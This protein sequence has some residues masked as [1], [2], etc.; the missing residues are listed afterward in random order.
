MNLQDTKKKLY[1]IYV[2][3]PTHVLQGFSG[4]P[5]I[6]GHFLESF[7]R[8]L[9]HLGIFKENSYFILCSVMG[10]VWYGTFIGQAYP[11]KPLY[12]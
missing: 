8:E 12:W 2:L 3:Q 4:V 6:L 9:V 7:S 5:L 1:F 11:R 10:S